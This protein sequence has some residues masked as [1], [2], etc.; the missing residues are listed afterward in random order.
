MQ[1]DHL[2]P[3]AQEIFAAVMALEPH[4]RGAAPAIDAD[5]HLPLALAQDLM[6]AGIFRMGVPRAYGGP[7]LDPMSQVRIVEELA[8]I[9]GSVGWLSMIATA[10]SFLAAFVEPAAAQRIFGGFDSVLAG[11]VRPPQRADL[12]EG[13]YRLSGTFHFGS[14][15]QHA[16]T[17][18]CGCTIYENGEPRRIGRHPEFRVLLVPASKA[19]IVDIWDTTGMR[20]TGSNDM[21]I[22]NVFVPFS[23]SADMTGRPLCPSPLYTFPPLFLV[24]HAGVPLGIARSALDFV[25]ELSLRKR[26]MPSGN[27]LREDVEFQE[28]IA[29]AEAHFSAARAYVYTTLED[30]WKTLSEGGRLST[31]QRAHYRMMI[32]YSHQAAKQVISTLYDTASTSSIFRSGRLDRDLR[33]IMTACQHRVVH[34]RMYRP[35]GRLLMD[36]DPGEPMF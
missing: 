16:S 12:V 28:T 14:G 25:E 13:G 36:L 4:I 20:G 22:D 3:A 17:I 9:E 27:P 21:V 29:W 32:T 11:Q 5:R 2:S 1:P 7:E 15:C 31:R 23:D 19:T 24:S 33:D 34:L 30:L 10:A 26:V 35:A 18:V 6:R 8:R